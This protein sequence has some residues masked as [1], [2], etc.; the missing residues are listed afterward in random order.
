MT[1]AY[2]DPDDE[3]TNAVARLRASHDVRV[4]LVL[5]TGSRIATS[6]INFRLLAHE[7]REHQR[8]LAVVTAEPGVR[9]VAVSAGL[10]AYA[11]VAEY[12]AALHE[13][14]ASGA[15]ESLAPIAD[16]APTG[17][18]RTRRGTG[19]AAS[20]ASGGVAS[21][22]ASTTVA[23]GAAAGTAGSVA[24]PP[25]GGAGMRGGPPDLPVVAARGR[26]GRGGGR[27][28]WIGISGVLVVALVLAAGW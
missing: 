17:T 1:I 2:L 24:P 28:I 18:R 27:W 11:T 10:P 23:A 8:V 26:D 7:A 16:G 3:I 9:A 13:A 20:A 12:E 4:A 15:A 5:P 21:A 25:L 6:R 14:G 22:A 19:K